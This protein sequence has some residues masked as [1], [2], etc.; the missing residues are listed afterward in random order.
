KSFVR[1]SLPFELFRKMGHY[2]PRTKLCEV[3]LND[4]YDGIY[5]MTEKI[6]RDKNRV[7]ISSIDDNDNGGDSITGG[8]IFGIDYF[9]LSD[10]WEGSYSPP[11]YSGKSVHFVYNYPGYDEITSQQKTYLKDYVSSFER[12]LYG[13]SFT[14][15]TTGYRSYVNVNSFIDYFIISELS[16]NVDGYKKSCF[17]YKTRKSKGGLLQAGPVWDFDWAWKDI[18]DCSI[19]QNTDGSGWAYKI[20]ECDPWP[21]PTGWIPRMMEDPLFVDQ[22]KK[23]Y[24][25]FRKNILSN[26]SL[27]SHLDSVSN[28]VKDAQS[29]HFKRWD[30]LGQ[31]YGSEKG[32]PAYTYEEEITMLKDWISRRL[33]WLD[34]QLLVEVTNTYQPEVKTYYCSVSPNPA[35]QSTTLKC[36]RPMTNVDVISLTGQK[37]MGLSGLNNT[38]YIMDVS[39]F[40]Q[41]LYLIRI[42]LDNGEEITQKLLVE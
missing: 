6:K 21:T 15:A 31:N 8:Y 29:R 7:N 11:G 13:S 12:V 23:R 35:N 25:S 14:N 32:D 19:F 41:G 33:T 9:E 26:S 37:V 5:V 1:N 4:S 20:L 30:I 2:A 16:R 22:L 39:G 42:S 40:R 27:D 28:F 3:I 24:S 38:E 18:W 34:S 17:Y 36:G 10:S